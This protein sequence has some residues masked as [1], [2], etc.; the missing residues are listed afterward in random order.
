MVRAA[1]MCS[2]VGCSAAVPIDA[3]GPDPEPETSGPAPDPDSAPDSTPETADS[4]TP[5]VPAGSRC[6]VTAEHAD[7]T[8]SRSTLFGRDVYSE[9]PLGEAPADGWPAVV[10]YQGTF[11]Q[12]RQAFEADVD[13]TFGQYSLTLTVAALL[14]AGYAVIAPETLG[15]GHTAWQTNV[16][17]WSLAWSTSAD[18]AFVRA[19]LDTIGAGGLGDLDPS[20]LYAMGISSGGFM[21]SRMAVSYPGVFRALVVHSGSYATCGVVCLVPS[22]PADHPPTRFLH[23]GD[24][25][26]VRIGDMERYLEALQDDGVDADAVI[27]PTAGHEWLAAGPDAVVEWF[28]RY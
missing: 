13:D 1:L 12:G 23:G 6:T 22:L 19:L 15:D 14:D 17:P 27:D 5:G 4:G 18:D 7:C 16:P 20:R 9:V 8:R 25:P 24:D 26:I 28:D 2:L 3:P 11:V 10:Y 21:T